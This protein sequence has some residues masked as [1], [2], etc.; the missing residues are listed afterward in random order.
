[1]NSETSVLIVGCGPTG[2][3]LG[4]ELARRGIPF[5]IVDDRPPNLPEDRAAFVKSRSLEIIAAYGLT[6]AFLANGQPIHGINF[7]RGGA[8]TAFLPFDGIDS[9]FHF[10][11]GIPESTTERLL[12]A[13]LERLG[14]TIER[15]VRFIG[16]VERKGDV[17][18]RLRTDIGEF[19]VSTGWIVGADGV[20]STV[21]EVGGI[22]FPGDVYPLRWGVIDGRLADWP[23]PG[24]MTAVQFSPLLYAAPIGDGRRRIYFRA[25]PGGDSGIGPVQAMIATLAPGVALTDADAPQLFR[26]HCRIAERFRSGRILLAGDAAHAISPTQAHGMNVGIQDAFNLGWKLALVARGAAPD[27]LLDTYERERRPVAELVAASGD[28]AERLVTNGDPEAS[29]VI[30]TA[31]ANDA[32]RRQMAEDE[33]E[34]A[35]R[36]APSAIV[37]EIGRPPAGAASAVGRRI[38][39][40]GPL[41]GPH[42]ATSLHRIVAHPDHT[43]LLCVG[44]SDPAAVASA[45]ASAQQAAGRWGAHLRTH[46]VSRNPTGVG[47][48]A[49]AALHDP[50]GAAHARLAGDD[51]TCLCLV[52]PDGHLGLRCPLPATDALARHLASTFR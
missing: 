48:A 8:E 50:T 36:Y 3:V 52:R 1:M 5:R 19:S 45:V 15:G 34:I 32:T 9:P 43:L 12:T 27:A 21:R 49:A 17:L 40:A 22:G 20:H 47:D 29:D 6:E 23:H 7:Y 31:L 24:D 14:G 51:G 44:Q 26:S 16:C 11:L 38:G 13:E 42:G 46:V 25:D 10:F 39:D 18:A 41:I 35:Y 28:D 33:A 30:R 2:L 4:I 37:E